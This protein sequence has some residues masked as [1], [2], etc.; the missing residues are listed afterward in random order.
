MKNKLAERCWQHFVQNIAWCLLALCM[1]ML[2]PKTMSGFLKTQTV[3]ARTSFAV[4]LTLLAVASS[5]LVISA[6]AGPVSN[7]DNSSSSVPTHAYEGMITD[8]RCVAKHSAA[9]GL[10]AAD[11]TRVCVHGGEQFALVDGDNVYVLEG[12]LPALKRMAGE[13]VRIFGAINGNK[14]SV[15]SVAATK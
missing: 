15:S 9:I 7:Q 3:A 14:I 11:C 12:D 2:V 5:L 4:Y 10:A 13:R 6:A 8:T 1:K